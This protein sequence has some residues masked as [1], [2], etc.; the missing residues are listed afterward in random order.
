VPENPT[1]TE[2]NPDHENGTEQIPARRIDR[3]PGDRRLRRPGFGLADVQLLTMR[4]T[5]TRVVLA[6]ALL[7]PT[8]TVIAET[9]SAPAA[10]ATLYYSYPQGTGWTYAGYINGASTWYRL[11]EVYDDA[12]AITW[13]DSW[14]Y[15]TQD[16]WGNVFDR[17]TWG[18]I[19][20]AYEN[21]DWEVG[22]LGQPTSNIF[23]SHW[24][25]YG[26][27]YQQNFWK[28]VIRWH[29]RTCR[30]YAWGGFAE[31]ILY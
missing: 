29:S 31:V 11:V 4:R 22:R 13:S 10:H 27:V 1:A 21:Y 28:A 2:R 8:A 16:Q 25:G 12:T 24:D 5:I 3:R 23:Y 15:W 6:L 19:R 14:E 9:A 18:P 30:C 7:A 26:P 20:Y 17:F